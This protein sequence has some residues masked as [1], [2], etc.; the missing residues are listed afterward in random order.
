MSQFFSQMKEII[1]NINKK[2]STLKNPKGKRKATKTKVDPKKRPTNPK[3]ISQFR[4]CL[5]NWKP[6]VKGKLAI[7]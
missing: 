1:A 7:I 6:S 2:K 4:V 5:P 3:E